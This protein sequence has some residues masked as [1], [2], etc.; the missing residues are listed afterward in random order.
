M[1][2]T[3]ITI[4]VFLL[5]FIIGVVGAEAEEVQ[6]AYSLDELIAMAL[7]HA[8]GINISR[9]EL[10]FEE[11]QVDRARAVLL[12]RLS[13]MGDYKRYTES[14]EFTQPVS[15]TSW[16]ARL[17]QSFSLSGRELTA[18]KVAK[19]GV[20]KGKFDLNAVKEEYIFKVADAFF[21][22][23]RAQKALE[24]SKA[25]QRRLT[26]HKDV[27]QAKVEVGA[28]SRTALLR[29]EAELASA[30]SGTVRAEGNLRLTKAMLASI[31]AIDGEYN[32]KRPENSEPSFEKC[33][34][35]DTDALNCLKKLAASQRPDLRSFTLQK[36]ISSGFVKYAKGAYWPTVSI[37]GVYLKN[38]VDP[39]S[40]FY[41]DETIYAGVT[42]SIPILDWGLRKAELRQA[43]ARERQAKYALSNT[44]KSAYVEVEN[45]YLDFISQGDI[46]D[47]SRRQLDFAKKN[48]E[49]VEKQFE[50]GLASSIDV[51]DANTLLVSS[52]MQVV[53]AELGYQLSVLR[54]KKETGTLLKIYNESNE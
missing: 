4:I 48:Y 34:P 29:A 8:E 16:G 20:R 44:E 10:Y 1:V 11:R 37:E 50:V 9:E 12:P 41:P 43:R 7:E 32:I 27:A 54:L 19:M 24:A 51:M 30:V 47:S 38:E 25:N 6:D 17:D 3:G 53:D 13:A 2:R 33:V 5:I 15:S 23:L 22:V 31:A 49:V 21:N 39:T 26:G 28:A 36:D 40:D 42:L 45:A 18:F 35:R 46:V 14:D 52:E